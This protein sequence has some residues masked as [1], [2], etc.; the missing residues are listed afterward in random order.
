[1]ASHHKLTAA[2]GMAVSFCDLLSPSQRG[3]KENTNGDVG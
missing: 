3:T 1:M 2:I